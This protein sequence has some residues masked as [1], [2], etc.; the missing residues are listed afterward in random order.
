VI[1]AAAARRVWT[2]GDTL[3]TDWGSA[4][5]LHVFCA[6]LA[7]SR[8]QFARFADDE[9]AATTMGLLAQCFEVLGGVPKTVLADRRGCLKAGV[10]ASVVVPT[11]DYARQLPPLRLHL[12]R[13][14]H[15]IPDYAAMGAAAAV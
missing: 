3:V 8:V 15:R 13:A 11:A 4:G 5:S 9:K 7:W 12:A 10:V 1:T 6:V 2:P 14:H